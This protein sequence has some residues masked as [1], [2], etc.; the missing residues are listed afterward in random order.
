M[1]EVDF[2]K[3]FLFSSSFDLKMFY[4]SILNAYYFSFLALQ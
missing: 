2:E 3:G 1:R 4:T